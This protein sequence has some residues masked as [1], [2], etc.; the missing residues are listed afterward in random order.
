[1]KSTTLTFVLL[2]LIVLAVMWSSGRLTRILMIA[3]GK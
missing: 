2:I 3:F 1:M